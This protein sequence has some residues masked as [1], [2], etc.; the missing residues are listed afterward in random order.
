VRAL[1]GTLSA[2][3]PEPHAAAVAKQAAEDA[4]YVAFEGRFRGEPEEIRERLASYV[5]LFQGLSPVLELGCGG[6]EFLELLR[7]QGIE[8]SGVE[9]NLRFVEACRL[10][11]L[12]VAH[13]DLV[14]FLGSRPGALLGGVFAAQVA[15]H[16][17][18]AALLET[19][20]ESHR[21]LRPG[22][23]LVLET[24]NPR[25]LVAF[26][27]IYNRD[28]SHERPLHP[29][30]LRFMAAAAG[31]G[32]VRIELRSAVDAASRLQAVPG[33]GLPPRAAEVLNENVQRLNDLLYGPQ[34]YA[35]IARR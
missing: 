23:L 7:G 3:A 26:L 10:R 22:G 8:A 17:P 6:G 29:D 21:V 1:I 16:L 5:E 33:E 28:L 11:G 9:A 32:D 4:V 13:G 35:L 20:R 19:L 18:P 25:S 2:R 27:E 12:E 34:E 14:A 15:E 30:T 31:F 24:V